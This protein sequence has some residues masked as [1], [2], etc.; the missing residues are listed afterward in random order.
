[1]N[2]FVAKDGS[3]KA[4]LVDQASLADSWRPVA[5]QRP[6]FQASLRPAAGPDVIAVWT[7]QDLF[8]DA[9]RC[10]QDLRRVTP[11]ALF[12]GD[13]LSPHGLLEATRDAQVVD[14]RG[15]ISCVVYFEPW[16]GVGGQQDPTG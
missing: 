13:H 5:A 9:T 7:H 2:V 4:A 3:Q 16:R 10:S 12:S 15:P 11:R 8:H 14:W 6:G 1:M